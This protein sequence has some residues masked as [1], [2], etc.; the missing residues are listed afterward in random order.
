MVRHLDA[1]PRRR[2]AR[3]GARVQPHRRI[4]G[5]RAPLES[6]GLPAQRDR[7]RRLPGG[8]RAM[9]ILTR[10]LIVVFLA[11]AAGAAA[12]EEIALPP[13]HAYGILKPGEGSD[14]TARNC[15]TC[16]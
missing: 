11:L 9:T 13:D 7:I 1:A 10:A 8:V 14:V 15:V 16:H 12:A 6:S 5:R 2:R 4:A 3:D